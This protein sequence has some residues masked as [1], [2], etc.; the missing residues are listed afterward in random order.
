M[1]YR[2]VLRVCGGQLLLVVMFATGCGGKSADDSSVRPLCV[3][4]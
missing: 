4:S 3:V 1:A 2:G